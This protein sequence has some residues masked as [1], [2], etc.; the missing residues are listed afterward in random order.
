MRTIIN[1]I[2]LGIGG[3]GRAL[4]EQVLATQAAQTRQ[5][6]HLRYVALAD[7]NGVV[8]NPHGLDEA[9][10]RELGAW[11]AE[12]NLLKDYGIGTAYRSH[13]EWL[14]ML[15]APATIIVDTTA[16]E[17]ATVVPA[18]EGVLTQ[19]GAVVLANK[20]PIAESREQWEI[21]MREGRTGYEATVGAG[22]PIISTLQSLI[23]TGDII[24]HVQGTFSGTLGYLM[25]QLQEGTPYSQAVRTAK[26]NGWTEPDPRDDL[27]GIDIARKA[28][29]L[30]R[31]LGW[32]FE[33]A[34]VE[35][36][37]LYPAEWAGLRVT[38]F[39]ARL[40]EMDQQM[41]AK[42]A[43]AH[44]AGQRLRY[45]ATVTP[46]SLKVGL[47]TVPPDGALGALKGSD[48]LIGFYTERYGERP[49]VV[50]GAGAGTHLTASAV[51]G[52]ILRLGTNLRQV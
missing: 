30:A 43:A 35:V 11:K 13:N 41:G 10:V 29:I 33:L 32:Q 49:L 47:A 8:A 25:S 2:Q 24:H 16:A 9:V 7:S 1:I 46:T 31:T 38:D 14:A 17:G 26:A 52:D 36:E 28:L 51:L 40:E 27:G 18:F 23:D 22:M 34:D 45:T 21:L 6:I 12:G 20:K 50:Q 3:V 42:V 39:M 37:P 44:D 4:I 5:G 15:I 19:G 48:N